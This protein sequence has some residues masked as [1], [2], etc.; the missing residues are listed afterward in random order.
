MGGPAPLP[1]PGSSIAGAYQYKFNENGS[2][3]GWVSDPLNP[4][5]NTRDNNNFY[6]SIHNPTIHY[7]QPNSL[8]GII[9]LSQPPI[10]AYIFPPTSTTNEAN[11]IR[12]VLGDTIYTNVGENYNPGNH[13]FSFTPPEPLLSGNHTLKVI[14]QSSD[15]SV[16]ADSTTFIVQAGIVQLLTQSNERHLRPTKAIV[17][18]VRIPA[19]QVTLIQ[20]DTDTLSVTAG[21]DGRFELGV[22]LL[23]GANTFRALA[24]D[25]GGVSHKSGTITINYVVD[26]A[27][28]P[29]VFINRS[30]KNSLSLTFAANDPD[31]DP[32]SV[33][34][35]SDDKINPEPLSI[36]SSDERVDLSI[37]RTPGEYFFDPV[38]TEPNS[39]VGAGRNYFTFDE[40]G[41]LSF[42][43]VNKNP[44]WVRDAIIYE[45]FVQHNTASLSFFA[46]SSAKRLRS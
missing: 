35:T 7:L 8:S 42:S 18:L 5:K 31:G 12:V 45:I 44:R 34:W 28:K 20:N 17:G 30:G 19:A 11:S 41:G 43:G 32:V 46:P 36:Q 6:L 15:G 23:E 3:T 21:I 24:M 29:V 27:P 9:T 2:S 16:S 4:R 25:G 13:F 14:A 39:N 26:H 1:N 37:P 38:V 22:D 10:T 33:T 40:R